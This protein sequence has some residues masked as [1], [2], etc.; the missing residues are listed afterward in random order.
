M[1]SPPGRNCGACG[2]RTCDDF[3]MRLREGRVRETDCPFHGAVT[4]DVLEG[5]TYSGSDVI[6]QKYDFVI[7]P[8]PGEPSARKIILPFRPDMTE[9]MEVVK[10]DIVLGRPAGAGCPVQHVIRVLNADYV[11][12]VIT[13]HVVGP[14]FSRNGEVKD[15]KEYHML[16]F[17]GMAVNRIKE[18]EFGRRH[19]FLPGSCMMHRAH[20]GLVSMVIDRPYGTQVRLEDIIIL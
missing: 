15:M 20:T 6:S 2:S 18:P 16:G 8:L 12:G 13:G 14:A 5:A 7:A 4:S 10:G 9:R 17:E 1:W 3:T 19:Y 11:T